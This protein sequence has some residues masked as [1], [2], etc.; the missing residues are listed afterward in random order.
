M[1]PRAV[2]R[3]LNRFSTRYR[4]LPSP[5]RLTGCTS[6][7]GVRSAQPACVTDRPVVVFRQIGTRGG[8]DDRAVFRLLASSD[9][10]WSTG[11]LKAGRFYAKVKATMRC[12]QTRAG[13]FEPPAVRGTGRRAAESLPTST[14]GS[15]ASLSSGKLEP[16]ADT[17]TGHSATAQQVLNPAPEAYEHA[18]WRGSPQ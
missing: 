15:P 5:S 4:N 8:G 10:K 12:G 17:N 14:G 11:H 18:T 6:R 9:G 2:Q 1:G 3:R 13:P 16:M 7:A